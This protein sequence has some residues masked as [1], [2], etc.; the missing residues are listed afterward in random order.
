M[1]NLRASAVNEAPHDQPT[2]E[3]LASYLWLSGRL[4]YRPQQQTASVPFLLLSYLRSAACF[5]MMFAAA[6]LAN[7][8][9]ALSKSPVCKCCRCWQCAAAAA[10]VDNFGRCPFS[11]S[12]HDPSIWYCV[13]RKLRPK[14]V[15]LLNQ[16]LHPPQH[17][18]GES[19]YGTRIL[20]AIPWQVQTAT[21]S[22]YTRQAH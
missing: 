19:G 15:L 7:A 17:A 18:N 21:P 14:T 2:G 13:E 3:Y 20:N 10:F 5:R 1:L 11:S 6:P 16:R 22:I 4:E 9:G 8:S 12:S